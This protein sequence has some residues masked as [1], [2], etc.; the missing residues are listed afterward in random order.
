MGT[1][2]PEAAE[3]LPYIV[4]LVGRLVFIMQVFVYMFMVNIEISAHN[5]KIKDYYSDLEERSLGWV[6][7]FNI[8]YFLA[9]V[10]GIVL[11]L[12]GRE[13]FLAKDIYL[14]G[15]SILFSV[16]L[17]VIS[18]LGYRQ[19]PTSTNLRDS[20]SNLTELTEPSAERLAREL[21][22]LFETEKYFLNRDFKILDVSSKLGTNRTYISRVIN[23]KFGINFTTFVNNYR[24]DFA[25]SILAENCNITVEELADSSGFGSVNSLYRAFE[26]KENISLTQYRK[27][28]LK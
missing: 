22:S 19:K 28:S 24:V 27:S 25:K 21:I 1:A 15:P 9:S 18:Y 13:M 23:Q 10:A 4:Y 26:S 14:L 17:F 2:R 12:L 6:K 7:V 8:T 20:V 3:I 11:A 5:D 16:L